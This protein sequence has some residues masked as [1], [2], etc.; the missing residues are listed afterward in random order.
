MRGKKIKMR[1]Y[2]VRQDKAG[3]RGK[4]HERGEDEMEAN[5]GKDH[6]KGTS[7]RH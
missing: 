6:D 5:E 3:S 4:G 7:I 2:T 1:R